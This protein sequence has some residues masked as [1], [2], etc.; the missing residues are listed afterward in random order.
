MQR[1]E[2]HHVL[3]RI[4]AD[5]SSVR[6]DEIRRL[7]SAPERPCRFPE[8]KARRLVHAGHVLYEKKP[9]AGVLGFLKHFPDSFSA[10][11]ALMKTI[12]GLGMKEASHFLR[13]LG[14]GADLAVIDI[15]VRRFMAEMNLV[16]RTTAFA[17][18]QASYLA[19][20]EILSSLAFSSGLALGAMDLAIWRYMRAR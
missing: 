3:A 2:A 14:Y 8:Q 17:N 6:T 12:P 1:L 15:H 10:R 4:A 19:M 13:N 16:D 20:E 7:L 18:S 11:N 5:P 9:A